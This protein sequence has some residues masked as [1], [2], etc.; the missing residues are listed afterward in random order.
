M[1]V[2]TLLWLS[3]TC[4]CVLYSFFGLP[5][6]TQ[7][8]LSDYKNQWSTQTVISPTFAAPKPN[9]WIDLS[10][11]ESAQIIDYLHVTNPTLGLTSAENATSW[12]NAII[13]MEALAPSK[14]DT[15]PFL[16]GDGAVPLRFARVVVNQG[17][18]PE[19]MICE[20]QVGPL[21][22]T[23]ASS[24]TP[25][26]N[27]HTNGEHCVPNPLPGQDAMQDWFQDASLDMQDVL[28]NLLGDVV[29]YGE[30][31]V[32]KNLIL[33]GR[34]QRSQKTDNPHKTHLWT[35]LH[36]RNQAFSL[37]PQGLY[38]Q[39]DVTSRNTSNWEVLSCF[40]NGKMYDSLQALHAAASKPGFSK[41]AP[42]I[43]DGWVDTVDWSNANDHDDEAPP[44]IMVQPG[45]YVDDL[46]T[47]HN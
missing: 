43:N 17:A 40:Y 41:S 3:V 31:G 42:N 45:I 4:A 35:E 2:I 14:K 29:I 26:I 9:V 36:T 47:R 30:D 16:D 18:S 5:S 1:A 8:F 39:L 20:Y 23:E 6:S 7:H 21:P 13:S 24:M 44:P 19:P 10:D 12:D 34:M 32:I 38:L 15:V 27:G 22:I 33:G 11:S 25:L 46:A 37:L 28:A